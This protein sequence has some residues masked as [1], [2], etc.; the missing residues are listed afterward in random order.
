MLLLTQ[1][2]TES[3]ERYVF[4]GALQCSLVASIVAGFFLSMAWVTLLWTLF[5]LCMA[6]IACEG[7]PMMPDGTSAAEVPSLPA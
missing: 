5:V 1:L 6:T 2:S 7:E 3:K 4:A